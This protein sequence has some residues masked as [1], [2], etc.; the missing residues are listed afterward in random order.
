M[1]LEAYRYTHELIK[2]YQAYPLI[3]KSW[4]KFIRDLINWAK[5]RIPEEH[6]KTYGQRQKQIINELEAVKL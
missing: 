2:G 6:L 5:S 3:F 4:E 1:V